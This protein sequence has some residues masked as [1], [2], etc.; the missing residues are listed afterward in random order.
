LQY[1]LTIWSLFLGL[2]IGSFLNVVIWRLPRRES[3]VR[4]GSHCPRCGMAIR[5]YDNI[6]VL[7]W[8]LL[9]G[10]CRGCRARIAVRYPLVE[11][12]TGVAYVAAFLALGPRPVVLLVW[13]LIAVFVALAFIHHDHGIVPGRVLFPATVCGWAASAAL[14]P[15]HGWYYVVGSVGAA[16][17]GLVLLML[18]PGLV[19]ISEPKIALLLGSVLGPA[20]V[21]GV[22]GVALARLIVGIPLSL[23]PK[24]P[25][26]TKDGF[27]A[28]DRTT[29]I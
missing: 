23:L 5:W 15:R 9:R 2:V 1:Y 26:K 7:S 17:V 8:L 25:I 3:L 18:S 20:V 11:L 24:R 4:P 21:A 28:I 19:T 22:A 29:G 12:L 14:D 13:A 16:A 10:R 6:P 27:H